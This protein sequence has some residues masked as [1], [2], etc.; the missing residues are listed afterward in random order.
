MIGCQFPDWKQIGPI[1]ASP[2]THMGVEHMVDYLG[3]DVGVHRMP[4]HNT[5][6]MKQ[7]LINK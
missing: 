3:L 7:E 1:L 5:D 6:D 2:R 4:I